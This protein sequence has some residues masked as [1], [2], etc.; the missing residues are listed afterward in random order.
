ME[1]QGYGPASNNRQAPCHLVVSEAMAKQADDVTDVGYR[2]GE[3]RR[4]VGLVFGC[5]EVIEQVP[6]EKGPQDQQQICRLHREW[7]RKTIQ[8]A[9][10]L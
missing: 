4:L 6:Y 2:M 8:G 7:T 1:A 10:M 9:V 3:H 5:V